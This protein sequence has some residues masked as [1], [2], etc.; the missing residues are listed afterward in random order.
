MDVVTVGRAR[1]LHTMSALLGSAR[2]LLCGAQSMN[3]DRQCASCSFGRGWSVRTHAVLLMGSAATTL[4]S[5]GEGAYVEPARTFKLVCLLHVLQCLVGAE[6]NVSGGTNCKPGETEQ[7]MHKRSCP[8]SP[9]RGDVG[10]DPQV[11]QLLMPHEEYGIFGFW[12]AV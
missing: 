12:V 1:L 4:I 7:E 10:C 11:E 9:S 2:Q 3:I 6:G 8:R 5:R